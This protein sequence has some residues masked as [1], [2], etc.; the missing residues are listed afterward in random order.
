MER[1]EQRCDG[2]PESGVCD[3]VS[4]AMS[5]TVSAEVVAKR[6]IDHQNLVKKEISRLIINFV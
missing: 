4:S 6:K 5:Q 1:L 2:H 3:T